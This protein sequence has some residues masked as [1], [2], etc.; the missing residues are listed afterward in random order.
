[1]L[2]NNEFLRRKLLTG[3][4]MQSCKLW[5]I[6]KEQFNGEDELEIIFWSI[7]VI[8]KKGKIMEHWTDSHIIFANATRIHTIFV[9]QTKMIT[10]KRWHIWIGS[11]IDRY[12]DFVVLSMSSDLDRT[13][14]IF[15]KI[16]LW[17]YK[18]KSR[19]RKKCK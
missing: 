17:L 5:Q 15:R 11:F 8:V 10:R 18:T 12:D 9:Y 4:Q 2:Y 19:Q 1:M 6:T 16:K 14:Q 13:A 3:N 7:G